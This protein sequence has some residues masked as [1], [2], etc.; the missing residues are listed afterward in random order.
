MNA[1][2]NHSEHYLHMVPPAQA[3][4]ALPSHYTRMRDRVQ[5]RQV[6]DDLVAQVR[7]DSEIKEM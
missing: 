6:R 5:M 7:G 3:Q 1:D 4:L 2:K